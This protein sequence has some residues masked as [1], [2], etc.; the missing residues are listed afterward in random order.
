MF[1][2]KPFLGVFELISNCFEQAPNIYISLNRVPYRL[3]DLFYLCMMMSV[4]IN[5]YIL[6]YI[7]YVYPLSSIHQL[8]LYVPC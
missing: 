5:V 4:C 6:I 1:F 2:R 3:L 7:K 8:V